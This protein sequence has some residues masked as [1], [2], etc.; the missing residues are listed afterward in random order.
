MERFQIENIAFFFDTLDASQYHELC[1]SHPDITM[2][3]WQE[4]YSHHDYELYHPAETPK[5][6]FKRR[7]DAIEVAIHAGLRKYA[8]GVL[9][10]LAEPQRD[11]LLCIA[12][13]HYLA[14]TFGI[15]P[16]AFGLVRLQPS[17]GAELVDMPWRVCEELQLF[18]AAILRLAFADAE[19]IVTSREAPQQVESLLRVAATFTNATCTTV[20]GGYSRHVGTGILR[21]GQFY[22]GSPTFAS[23]KKLVQR[24]GLRLNPSRPL[25]KV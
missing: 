15:P 10:G 19:I 2:V 16:S 12:H 11:V 22:H 4:T 3:H 5:G 20:P 1:H 9:F 14:D 21:N 23:V 17:D 7:L 18:L 6:D 25:G 8:I 13:G 24:I